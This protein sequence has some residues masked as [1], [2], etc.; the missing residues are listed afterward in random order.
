[1]KFL[2]GLRQGGITAPC[3]FDRPINGTLFRT[4]VEQFLVPT[5]KPPTSSCSTTSAATRAQAPD[6]PS[7]PQAHT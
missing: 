4:W 2:A 7:E 6:K 5:L 3:V 1:M